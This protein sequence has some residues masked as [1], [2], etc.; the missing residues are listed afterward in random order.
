MLDCSTTSAFSLNHYREVFLMMFRI[1]S[2]AKVRLIVNINGFVC[3][4]V[5]QVRGV[6]CFR[7]GVVLIRAMIVSR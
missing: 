4:E 6:Y 2:I 7:I 3:F 1:L 5:F